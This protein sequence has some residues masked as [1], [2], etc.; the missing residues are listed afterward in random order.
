M[1]YLKSCFILN[2]TLLVS[3]GFVSTNAAELK[4]SVRPRT[5]IIQTVQVNPNANLENLNGVRE[6]FSQFNVTDSTLIHEADP[7]QA[8]MRG[9]NFPAPLA[10]D[11]STKVASFVSLAT[12]QFAH[13]WTIHSSTTELKIFSAQGIDGAKRYYRDNL[14][15]AVL[16]DGTELYVRVRKTAETV[17][18]YE[19]QPSLRACSICGSSAIDP[20]LS[21]TFG[22]IMFGA[23][24]CKAGQ[25]LAQMTTTITNEVLILDVRSKQMEPLVTLTANKEKYR[26]DKPQW[27]EECAVR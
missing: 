23:R 10:R 20:K 13:I 11:F 17:S 6:F 16:A 24:K 2:V 1:K 5:Y 21:M 3:L 12:L 15:P 9:Q 26:L 27:L 18:K 4:L 8:V 7:L 25:A 19:E 22:T 14:Y